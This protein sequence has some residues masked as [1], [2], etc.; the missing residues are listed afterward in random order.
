MCGAYCL[1]HPLID[2]G[3]KKGSASFNGGV[4][5]CD[6]SDWPVKVKVNGQIAHNHACGCTKCW[7]PVGATFSIVAVA[8]H[9]DVAVVENGDKLK[10]VDP[11]ALISAPCL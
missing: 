11:T 9:A 4:L 5:V 10:V 7:K 1:I 2:N 3:I 6:C 8:H